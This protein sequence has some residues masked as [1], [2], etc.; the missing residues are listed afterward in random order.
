MVD[1]GVWQQSAGNIAYSALAAKTTVNK[2]K[3]VE[4]MKKLKILPLIFTVLVMLT[5]C[6]NA[7]MPKE[8][9]PSDKVTPFVSPTHTPWPSHFYLPSHPPHLWKGNGFKFVCETGGFTLEFAPEME[10]KFEFVEDTDIEFNTSSR[11]SVGKVAV[12]L[13]QL[14]RPNP[15]NSLGYFG[16]FLRFSNEIWTRMTT[17]GDP[18]CLQIGAFIV[19]QD[20]NTVIV[21]L[22][23]T[24]G[25]APSG[26]LEE[27]DLVSDAIYSG[28]FEVYFNSQ[29]AQAPTPAGFVLDPE[30]PITELSVAN[31][32]VMIRIEGYDASTVEFNKYPTDPVIRQL[33]LANPRFLGF[34]HV[35]L[36]V[37]PRE[38]GEL[39]IGIA[40]RKSA[41][42]GDDFVEESI[43]FLFDQKSGKVSELEVPLGREFSEEQA[44][45]T[46]AVLA[47]I[48]DYGQ[49]YADAQEE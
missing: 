42:D 15:I 30:H 20:E 19:A 10:A 8:V 4:N 17:E 38:S 6:D 23:D 13:Y 16:R 34:E 36:S 31:G 21:F 49:S 9:P 28:D 5:A 40:F 3:D 7:S 14:P 26:T 44:K 25:P 29:P 12:E 32:Y 22:M 45:R 11:Y 35:E 33:Y 46:G 41:N 43:S 39:H 37:E 2:Y 48:F 27:Y 1:V 18:I 47:G 24:G